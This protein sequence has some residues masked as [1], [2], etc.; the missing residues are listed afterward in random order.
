[1]NEMGRNNRYD[2]ERI[3]T[4]CS[5]IQRYIRDLEDLNIR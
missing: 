2:M 4:I 5:D 1:M 3:G